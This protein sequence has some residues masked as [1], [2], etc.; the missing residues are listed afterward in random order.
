[1]QGGSECGASLTRKH[2]GSKSPPLFRNVAHIVFQISGRV[3]VERD[4]ETHAAV[5][6]LGVIALNATATT[7]EWGADFVHEFSRAIVHVNFLHTCTLKSCSREGGGRAGGEGVRQV[8]IY[9]LRLL[10]IADE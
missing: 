10:S 6:V 2:F 4:L 8:L 3:D 7:T 9:V 1:V 5:P